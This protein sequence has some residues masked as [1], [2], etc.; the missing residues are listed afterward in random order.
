[1]ENLKISLTNSV[2]RSDYLFLTG[3]KLILLEILDTLIIA[4][5]LQLVF[6]QSFHQLFDQFLCEIQTTIFK[7][8][9]F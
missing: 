9:K 6:G 8:V 3:I 1:M 7:K 5:K 4:R 2:Q